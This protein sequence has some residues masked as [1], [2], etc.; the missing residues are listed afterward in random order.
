[1]ML[2]TPADQAVITSSPTSWDQIYSNSK[3][4][5]STANRYLVF[6]I[7][8]L[9]SLNEYIY[10]VFDTPR[11][12]IYSTFDIRWNFTLRHNPNLVHGGDPRVCVPDPALADHEGGGHD[13]DHPAPR[14]D[15]HSIQGVVYSKPDQ[16]VVDQ[17]VHQGCE[18]AH[19]EGGPGVS[20][21][22]EGAGGN[23]PSQGAINGQQQAPLPQLY[24]PESVYSIIQTK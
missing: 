22:A 2:D 4:L 12:N 6:T 15:S 18:D 8:Y 19:N 24:K 16:A 20:S 17:D 5:N 1:M 9:N 10:A 23:H 14:V 13:T 21:V 7:W 11:L 3:G